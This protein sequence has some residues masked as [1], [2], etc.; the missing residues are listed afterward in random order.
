MKIILSIILSV[1]IS[2]VASA[3]SS[4]ST[5]KYIWK[6][7]VTKVS[8]SVEIFGL[9]QTSRSYCVFYLNNVDTVYN[10]IS[11]SLFNE[12]VNISALKCP[13]VKVSFYNML[14]SIPTKRIK[15][16]AEELS[17]FILTDVQKRYPQIRTNNLIISGVDYFALV[18]LTAAISDPRKVNKT[19]LFFNEEESATLLNNVTSADAKKLKG[20]LY[21]YVNHQNKDENF[22]DSLTTN[23]ALNSSIVLYKF[24]HFG[25]LLSSNIFEEAY[26]WLLANG[27]N[28]IIRNDD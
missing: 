11:D 27:N 10:T 14:D 19:A 28:Y 21:F 6:N 1:F 3:Q 4:D 2:F 8:A 24:D 20:K 7:E 9:Q 22:A 12:F 26:N 5:V 18:A 16:Y 23:L 25:E 15:I 13:I 17:K